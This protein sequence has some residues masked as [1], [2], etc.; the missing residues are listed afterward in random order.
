VNARSNNPGLNFFLRLMLFRHITRDG[1]EQYFPI[2]R[3]GEIFIATAGDTFFA[4]A[5]LD[6][7]QRNLVMQVL[8]QVM[9]DEENDETK[10]NSRE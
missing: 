4:R 1:R 2:D 7:A 8:D 9:T 5:W 10:K 3:F 6:A